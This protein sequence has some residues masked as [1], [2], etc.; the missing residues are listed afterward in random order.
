MIYK[1]VDK[2]INFEN[3]KTRMQQTNRRKQYTM[4]PISAALT[5]EHRESRSVYKS[6]PLKIQSVYFARIIYFSA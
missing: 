2:A 6:K 1:I 4:P 5:I 3:I